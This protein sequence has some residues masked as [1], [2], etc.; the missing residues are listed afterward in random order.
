M[1][2]IKTTL[3]EDLEG[4]LEVAQHSFNDFY[5]E[6]KL[7]K[8]A[9]G[10]KIWTYV[11]KDD[12]KIVGFKIWYEDDGEIYD[13]LDAVHPDYQRRG[14]SSNLFLIMFDESIKNNY[15][16]IKLKTHEGYPEM[17]SLCKKL[18]FVEVNREPHHWRDTID[19]E[20]IFFEYDLQQH[21]PLNS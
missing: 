12:E 1:D 20:A 16:K 11:S 9:K 3:E 4:I 21:K 14:I 8:R 15:T 18:G 13:W 17:I 2:Y 7:L 6:Q 10:R 5:P 19:K